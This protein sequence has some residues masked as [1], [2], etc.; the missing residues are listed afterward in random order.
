MSSASARS[1]AGARAAAAVA[2]L[3]SP[4]DVL[5]QPQRERA[6][7]DEVARAMPDL[8]GARSTACYRVCEQALV[9]RALAPQPGER[10]LKLDLWNEAVNTRLLQWLDDGG[11][12]VTGIDL[13][14]VTTT[15]ARDNFTREGRV[16]TFAQAD[17]RALPFPDDSVDAV[18]TMGTIEHIAEYRQALGEVRRVLRPG[19]RALIGVP[20][21]WDIFGRPLLAWVLQRLGRY[22][23]SPERSFG[24]RELR[25]VVEDAGLRVTARTGLLFVPGVL[26][27]ADLALH[28]RRHPLERLSAAL[29]AP[30]E[31]AELQ[32]EWS[33]RLGYLL[34]VVA[35]KP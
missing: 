27:L 31:R 14:A 25:A 3:G 12:R 16:P 17:I 29:V 19:G 4:A 11:V 20:H 18:Y 1:A 22:P 7:W 26:R 15:R 32:W 6:H 30:F 2:L 13:S 10:L 23:Y 35:H 28:V 24:A 8:S 21:R 5:S 33:R 9:A 34:A